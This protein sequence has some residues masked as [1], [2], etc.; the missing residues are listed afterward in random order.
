MMEYIITDCKNVTEYLESKKLNWND[1]LKN[2]LILFKNL[3]Q[4][5]QKY[6]SFY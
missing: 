4:F 5:P 2:Q 3:Q 6:S 1:F